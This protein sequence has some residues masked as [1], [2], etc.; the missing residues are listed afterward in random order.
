MG[1][2]TVA[3][4]GEIQR[5]DYTPAEID[6]ALMALISFGSSTKAAAAL[7]EAFGF[8][9]PPSTLRNWRYLHADR[10]HEL[11]RQH[12]TELEQKAVDAKRALLPLLAEGIALGVN[13]TI[14]ELEAGDAKDPSASARNLAVISGIETRD[15]ML[16]TDRPTERRDVVTPEDLYRKLREALSLP[17]EA[18]EIPDAEVVTEASP[19][20]AV[21]LA[22]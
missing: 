7:D 19:K 17:G 12:G 4:A 3:R 10:Y 9:V 13:K 20:G 21:G 15:L 11:L 2:L 16:L 22:T 14:D 18:E 1:R 6:Q 5:H 8:D